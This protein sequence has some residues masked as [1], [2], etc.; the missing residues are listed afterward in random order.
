MLS[1][2]YIVTFV[3]GTVINCVRYLSNYP[4]DTDWAISTFWVRNKTISVI[5]CMN[6]N[7]EENRNVYE[8]LPPL[9]RIFFMVFKMKRTVMP[10][11]AI[12]TIKFMV[13]LWR[14]FLE[15]A[16]LVLMIFILYS[17]YLFFLCDE[18]TEPSR[19]APA[20]FP[21]VILFQVSTTHYP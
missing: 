17:A 8:Y 12:A 19:W 6:L 5:A 3:C 21:L 13:C 15:T 7:S 9:L 16:K 14:V 20:L 1:G 10:D 11:E 18:M 2:V 4:F